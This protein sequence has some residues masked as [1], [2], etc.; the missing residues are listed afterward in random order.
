MT[1]SI[2]DDLL[3]AYVD[4]E[5]DERAARALEDQLAGDAAARQTV[6]RLRADSAA[7]RAA[8]DDALRGPVPA[9]VHETINSAFLAGRSGARIPRFSA[10]AASIA[11]LALVLA[12]AYGF[13]EY[14]VGQALTRQAALQAADRAVLR[15]AIA[16]ALEHQVSGRNADWRNPDSG[17]GGVVTPVRTF[18]SRGGQWCREYASVERTGEATQ[19]RRA[20]ACREKNGGW[21]T[22]L[23][24]I[25]D[26]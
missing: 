3:M 6:A 2:D 20:I 1:M 5:L 7:V 21:K 9:R 19:T 4:G 23:E 17:N 25:G 11:L 16:Q 26:S 14:R 24:L 12:G 13:A 10:I 22:R 15:A 18:K 8:F